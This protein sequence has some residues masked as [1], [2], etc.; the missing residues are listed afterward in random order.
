M[1]KRNDNL[2]KH[3]LPKRVRQIFGKDM[4]KP[5]SWYI[6]GRALFITCS[7]VHVTLI[8]DRLIVTCVSFMSVVPRGSTSLKISCS[9]YFKR[10]FLLLLLFLIILYLRAL[11]VQL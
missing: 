1:L 6:H 7:C 9:Y 5:F 8:S 4:T 3:L 2:S 11:C 10:H